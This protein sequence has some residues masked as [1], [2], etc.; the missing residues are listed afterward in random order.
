MDSGG[1]MACGPDFPAL[2]QRSADYIDKIL[3][4]GKAVDLPIEQ[5][6][7]YLLAVNLKTAK[8]PGITIPPGDSAAG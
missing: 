8:T 7:R 1:L 2:F 3:R 4:G 6:T 5:P